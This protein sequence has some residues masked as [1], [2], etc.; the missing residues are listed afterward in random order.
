V[1]R[2]RFFTLVAAGV[3][4]G[5]AVIEE[6]MKPRIFY[7]IPSETIRRSRS[8]ACMAGAAAQAGYASAFVA[9]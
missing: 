7:S 8:P 5:P 9:L 4:F 2:R 1:D 3:A 6:M